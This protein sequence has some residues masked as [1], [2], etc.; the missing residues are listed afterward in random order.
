MKVR[1]GGVGNYLIEDLKDILDT[2]DIV[3]AVNQVISPLLISGADAAV[4]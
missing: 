3:P 4:R 2:S 1:A